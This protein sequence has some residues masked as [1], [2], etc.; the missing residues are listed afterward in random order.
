MKFKGQANLYVKINNKYVQR[1]TGKKGFYFDDKGEFETDN[2][3]LIKVIG[4][5]FETIEETEKEEY[6]CKKC[7]F[8]T[9]NKG[10]LMAHYREYHPKGDDK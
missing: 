4:Q 7:N 3:V 10:K 2:E 9:D 1:V 5:N 8:T 6:H